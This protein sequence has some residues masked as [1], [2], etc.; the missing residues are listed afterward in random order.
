MT[1]ESSAQSAP[2]TPERSA[3]LLLLASIVLTAVLYVIPYG[4]YVAYPLLLLSTLAHEMGHGI[5]ALLVGGEFESFVLYADTSGM[6]STVVGGRLAAAWVA[7]GGLVGPSVAA[8]VLFLLGTRPRIARYGLLV[9]AALLVLACVLV[10]RN[11][12]GILFVSLVAAAA[13]GIALRASPRVAQIA[14][15]F[16]G[17]QLALSV[18]SR[19]DYL[20]AAVAQT[21]NGEKLSDVALM[22]DALWLPFWLWGALC[23]AFSIAVLVLG[24]RLF[25][26]ATAP[27]TPS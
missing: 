11:L 3:R 19:G 22:A 17:T 23:G 21:A 9:V 12:F 20:F 14:S 18:F 2:P 27:P 8:V 13:G 24:L 16:I 4:H 5:A 6:A 15:V 1:M 10:V 26:R 7:A 25:W